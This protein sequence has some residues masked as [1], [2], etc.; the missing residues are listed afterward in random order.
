MRKAPTKK[1]NSKDRQQR[2]SVS[3]GNYFRKSIRSLVGAQQMFYRSTL[4]T[5]NELLY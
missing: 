3:V 2:K 1:Q 4:N 5:N